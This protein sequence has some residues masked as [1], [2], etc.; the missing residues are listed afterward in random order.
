MKPIRDENFSPVCGCCVCQ[1]KHCFMPHPGHSHDEV[2]Y[3]ALTAPA[4]PSLSEASPVGQQETKNED[5]SRSNHPRVNRDADPRDGE[6]GSSMQCQQM[7]AFRDGY[8]ADGRRLRPHYVR[9]KC[10]RK[11]ATTIGGFPVCTQHARC[12]W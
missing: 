6:Q 5:L 10:K 2:V 3:E 4:S 12:P 9:R 11:A 1:G 7:V 8:R